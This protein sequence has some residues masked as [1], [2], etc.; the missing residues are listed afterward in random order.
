MTRV[1]EMR[2]KHGEVVEYMRSRHLDAVVLTRRCNFAWYT[3]GGSSHVSTG[4]D[5]GVA[6]LLV[7]HEEA[8]CVTNAIEAPRMTDEEVGPLGIAVRS[9]DWF[10][11]SAAATL[12][13]GL[14][15]GRRVACDAAVAGLPEDVLE[16]DGAFDRLRWTLTPPEI[17]RYRTLGRE[18]ALS[19]ETACRRVRPGDTEEKL[20]ADI[21]G[22]LLGKG[23]RCP[24]VLIAADQRVRR[25]RH[26]IPAGGR[27]ERY[28]MGVCCG[29][30]GG[31]IVSNTRLFSFGKIDG[32][33]RRRHEKVCAVD[34]AM[35]A[36]TR[37][38]R[39]LGDVFAVARKAYADAG[40]PD[41]WKLHHQGGS[42]GYTGRDVR[43]RPGEATEVLVPQAFAWNP[44]IAGTKSE[45][46]VLV[47]PEGNE[48]ISDSGQW[49]KSPYPAD[50][51]D[52]PRC[53][54]LEM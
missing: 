4:G 36:A 19:L 24:V 51:R 15:K 14:L 8:Q 50:G 38:G 13:G 26:P 46:T 41:E 6:S 30:R 7:T 18:V 54:I 32:D 10:D 29:E 27:F 49:P 16:L 21:V 9:C 5:T 39:T 48:V 40:F 53:D 43:G 52:W 11:P 12:W 22:E 33:L 44:S 25:Y 20:A 23:I 47:L 34:A 28:G 42:T 31:L 45:D 37:P 3:A 2:H 35:I 1:E 17:E